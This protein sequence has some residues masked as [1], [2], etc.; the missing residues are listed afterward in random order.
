MLANAGTS[1]QVLLVEASP[2]DVRLT[3]EALRD[4]YPAVDCHL[5]KAVQPD[6]FEA[7]VESINNFWLTR[8]K[9]PNQ[10]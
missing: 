10:A 4:G 6:Q 8:V 2:G 3:P 5:S 7:L 1:L 9:L